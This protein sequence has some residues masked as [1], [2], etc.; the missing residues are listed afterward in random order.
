MELQE[1][2]NFFN[3]FLTKEELYSLIGQSDVHFLESK[4][5]LPILPAIDEE[6]GQA[7]NSKFMACAL[8]NLLNHLKR[9]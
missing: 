8:L 4:I 9:D 7:N 3:H 5:I 6:T 2:H 1:W